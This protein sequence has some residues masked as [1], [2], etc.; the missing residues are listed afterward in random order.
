MGKE[1]LEWAIAMAQEDLVEEEYI[2]DIDDDTKEFIAELRGQNKTVGKL[3][4]K[5]KGNYDRLT[6]CIE[7]KLP[8]K[9][10]RESIKETRIEILTNIQQLQEIERRMDEKCKGT[11]LDGMFLITRRRNVDIHTER[12]ENGN[13]VFKCP[14]CDFRKASKAGVENHMSDEHGLS[15]V[16]CPLCEYA[17]ASTQSLSTHCKAKHDINITFQLVM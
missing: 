15:E 14:S 11:R 16:D 17:T 8:L 5:Q 2:G 1:E 9:E 6:E 12:E 4:K 10:V 13:Y 7:N 3:Y